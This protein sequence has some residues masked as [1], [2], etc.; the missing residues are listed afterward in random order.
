MHDGISE[1]VELALPCFELLF[2]VSCKKL[3]KDA[4][5]I[6]HDIA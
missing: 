5:M 1:V 2:T 3:L 6:T 4:L